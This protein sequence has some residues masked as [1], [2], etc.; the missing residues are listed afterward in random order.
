MCSCTEVRPKSFFCLWIFWS[1]YSDVVRL[2]CIIF[3]FNISWLCFLTH[4]VLTNTAEWSAYKTTQT[5]NLIS[6]TYRRKGKVPK[7]WSLWNTTFGHCWIWSGASDVFTMNG[8]LT[9]LRLNYLFN[10]THLTYL[11]LCCMMKIHYFTWYVWK[12]CE[13]VVKILT[14]DFILFLFQFCYKT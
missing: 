2:C 3:N 14:L 13:R 4:C 1:S 7:R 5:A 6:F 11:L 12:F 10:T 8:Y 9:N